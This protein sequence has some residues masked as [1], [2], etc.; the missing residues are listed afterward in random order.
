[1]LR[2]NRPVRCVLDRGDDMLITGGRHPVLGKYKVRIFLFYPYLVGEGSLK[3][4]EDIREH[5]ETFKI[6]L[7]TDS[8]ALVV[9]KPQTFVSTYVCSFNS[10]ERL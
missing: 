9:R 6:L 5:F 7:G 3:K 4:K 1:M 2:T 8:A 10:Y